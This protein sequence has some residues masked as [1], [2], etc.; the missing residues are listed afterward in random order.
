MFT[1]GISHQLRPA[2]LLR[3][4]HEELNLSRQNLEYDLRLRWLNGWAA[5]AL[6]LPG[7]L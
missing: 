2:L 6:F 5:S 1:F 4:L 3:I 7:S